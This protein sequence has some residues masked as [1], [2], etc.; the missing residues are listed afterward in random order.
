M[1][2]G[3]DE[4]GETWA[5]G[6]Y[7]ADCSAK[8]V[9]RSG[10]N[11]LSCGQQRFIEPWSVG[12]E[13]GPD[14]ESHPNNGCCESGAREH[15]TKSVMHCHRDGGSLGSVVGPYSHVIDELNHSVLV[16]LKRQQHAQADSRAQA[17][18][19]QSDKC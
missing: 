8:P 10:S 11:A 2:F 14:C 6:W 17:T 3:D 9:E 18:P 12:S 15:S 16:G 5:I 13:P 7:S 1:G 4:S 19:N